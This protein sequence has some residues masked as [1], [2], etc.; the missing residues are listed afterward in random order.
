MYAYYEACFQAGP[1]ACAIYDKSPQAIQARVDRILERLKVQPIAASIGS[2][3]GSLDYGIVDFSLVKHLL[4]V[5]LYHPYGGASTVA[6]A[7]AA[8]EQGDANPLW[9]LPVFEAEKDLF[10]CSMANETSVEQLVIEPQFA[11]ACSDGTPVN[12]TFDQLEAWYENYARESS[13]A[14]GLAVRVECA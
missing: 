10:K 9:Q 8:L 1:Q 2:S 6:T 12:D 4:F 5:Y 14:G 13:F 7:L 11:I 3:P